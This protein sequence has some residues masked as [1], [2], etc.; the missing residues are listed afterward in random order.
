MPR[1]GNLLRKRKK[2]LPEGVITLVENEKYFCVKHNEEFL[3]SRR[4]I[5]QYWRVNKTTPCSKCREESIAAKYA[6]SYKVNVGKLNSN[7]KTVMSNY[8]YYRERVN[9]KNNI[10]IR[11]NICSLE[12]KGNLKYKNNC[13][14]GC[15]TQKITKNYGECKHPECSN[16]I[17]HRIKKFEGFC[18]EKCMNGYNRYQKYINTLPQGISCLESPSTLHEN[19]KLHCQ[20]HGDFYKNIYTRFGIDC[21]TCIKERNFIE[22][23]NKKYNNKYDYSEVIYV[24]ARQPVNVICPEHGRFKVTPNRHLSNNQGCPSCSKYGFD[25]NK[26]GILYYISILGGTY[27]KLGITNRTVRERFNNS[28]TDEV[29]VIKEIQYEDGYELYRVEQEILKD[30]KYALSEFNYFNPGKGNKEIF[31]WD[32]LLWDI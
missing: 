5:M 18:S 24:N 1:K 27:Y 17:K 19:I 9:D 32:V 20:K 14:N 4:K 28:S 15:N 8:E 3:S 16:K 13:P 12:Y 22:E 26:P 7:G 29:K 10:I 30:F 2:E 23:S 25:K 21:P 11:C 31:K 6:E